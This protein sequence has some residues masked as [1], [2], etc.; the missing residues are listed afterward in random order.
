MEGISTPIFKNLDLSSSGISSGRRDISPRLPPP[1]LKSQINYKKTNHV[2]QELSLCSSMYKYQINYFVIF[3]VHTYLAKCIYIPCPFPYLLMTF[4]RPALLN[5][6]ITE[7]SDLF[8][9]CF[10][11]SRS[12]LL[13]VCSVAFCTSLDI[14]TNSSI[15]V[16]CRHVIKKAAPSFHVAESVII[17]Q[18]C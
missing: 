10:Q 12:Q 18:M 16:K 3:A 11:K 4:L 2:V 9:H 13:G 15:V 1:S 14:L 17:L 7:V 6:W 8:Q 5:F